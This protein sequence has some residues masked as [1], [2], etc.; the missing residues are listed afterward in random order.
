MKSL[1][2]RTALHNQ[3]GFSLIELL[4]GLALLTLLAVA[5]SGAFD[6]SR[7]RAQSLLSMMSELGSAQARQKNDT[8]CYVNR[9]DALYDGSQGQA[10]ASNYCSRTQTKTWNGPYVS[11]FTADASGQVVADKVAEGVLVSFQKEDGGMGTRYFI[12]AATVPVDVARQFL[13]EC[14][15]A[16]TELTGTSAFATNKCRLQTA[17]SGPTV[18]VEMLYDETR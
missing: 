7:S 4:V 3:G 12:R 14:N 15:N 9:P 5:I 1:N 17:I 8:G 11:R 13:Q 2:R 18:G 16:A 6:G 10:A